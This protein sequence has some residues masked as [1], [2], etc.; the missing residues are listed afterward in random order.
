MQQVLASD[1]RRI[2]QQEMEWNLQTTKPR[3]ED[4]AVVQVN[5]F[6]A[7]RVGYVRIY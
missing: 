4:R 3:E 7:L 6:E 5:N 2:V 1:N